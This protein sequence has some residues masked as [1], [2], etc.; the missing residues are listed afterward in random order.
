MRAIL[1]FPGGV[2]L[3]SHDARLVTACCDRILV[4]DAGAVTEFRG[5]LEDYRAG[6]KRAVRV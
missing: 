3:V 5:G 4:C 2:V 6:L 1:D